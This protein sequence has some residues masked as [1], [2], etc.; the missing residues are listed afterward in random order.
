MKS[1]YDSASSRSTGSLRRTPLR[2]S[3]DS[4]NKLIEVHKQTIDKIAFEIASLRCECESLHELE[5]DDFERIEEMIQLGLNSYM[6]V[7]VK[8]ASKSA[9]KRKFFAWVCVFSYCCS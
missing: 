4:Y 3:V 9:D 8:C 5:W 7:P 2:H 6:V 1:P